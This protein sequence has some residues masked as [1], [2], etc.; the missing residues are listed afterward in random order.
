MPTDR[1]EE[2]ELFELVVEA[3]AESLDR[4]GAGEESFYEVVCAPEDLEGIRT[5]LQERGLEI[6]V[7]ELTRLPKTTVKIANET[8]AEK[9]LTLVGELEDHE[10]VQTVCANFDIP[11]E[12]VGRLS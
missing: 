3:G 12:I 1:I 4:T 2:E 9:V 6:S 8:A 11:D 7:C 10:D 5:A